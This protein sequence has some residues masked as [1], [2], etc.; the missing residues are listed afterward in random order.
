MAVIVIA[1]AAQLGDLVTFLIMGI[2]YE[3]N[4]L[5]V[6]TPVPVA[7]IVKLLLICV[8]CLW[9][10]AASLG[11]PKVVAANILVMFMGAAL[12]VIGTISNLQVI[13]R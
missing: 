4:P 1:I 9:S 12:G 6:Q 2:E 5:V 11:N 10:I 7:A 3:L 8:I 13:L